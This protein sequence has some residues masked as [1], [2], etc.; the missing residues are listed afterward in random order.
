MTVM[1]R[2]SA[3]IAAMLFLTTP[4]FAALAPWYQRLAEL[5]AVID[6]SGIVSAFGGRSVERIEYISRDLY[7]VTGGGCH[8]DAKI[9]SQP[10]PSEMVGGRKFTVEV[11][12][13][14]CP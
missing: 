2:F 3:A 9:V 12:P 5:R 7:R 1:K 10:M 11:G 13:L 4:A 8:L 6:H 14:N